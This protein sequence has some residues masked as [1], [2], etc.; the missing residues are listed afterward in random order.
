ML[1]PADGS[2]IEDF[3]DRAATAFAGLA[4]E[5]QLASGSIDDGP[6]ETI[7]I[8]KE[9]VQ[10]SPSSHGGDVGEEIRQPETRIG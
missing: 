10:S 3:H 2:T 9:G 5:F 7:P 1:D 4:T 6:A 8:S